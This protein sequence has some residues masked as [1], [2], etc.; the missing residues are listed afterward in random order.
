M[1]R[2]PNLVESWPVIREAFSATVRSSFSSWIDVS[3]PHFEAQLAFAL[4]RLDD[5]IALLEYCEL[6]EKALPDRARDLLDLGAGNGGVALAFANSRRYRVHTLDVVPNIVLRTMRLSSGREARPIYHLLASGLALPYKSES[7]D[8][9]LL[10]DAIEHIASPR[11]LGQEI[12]RVLR[13]GG[14]CIVTTAARLKYVFRPDPHYG[15]R[16]LV[17][18]PNRLQQFVVDWIARRRVT[19]SDGRK[20]PAYD[21]DHF[22]WHASEIGRLFP[23]AERIHALYGRPLVG[24]AR[25]LSTEW[26]RWQL[27]GFLFD[28]VLIYKGTRG[29]GSPR[30]DAA[31]A[32]APR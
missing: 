27:R 19:G 4:S 21:V 5:G 1:S 28:H 9:L 17:V 10:V 3:E 11:R 15:V 8:V 7:F 14:L 18:L 6:H 2:L 31:R 32:P 20:W 12:M 13:P 24:A 23:G 26:W 16:G 30:E 25:A 22:Y 29:D